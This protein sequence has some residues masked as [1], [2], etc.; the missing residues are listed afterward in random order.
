[1]N[2]GLFVAPSVSPCKTFQTETELARIL[3][4]LIHFLDGPRSR[5]IMFPVGKIS[6]GAADPT[7]TRI[8]PADHTI[9]RKCRRHDEQRPILDCAVTMSAHATAGRPHTGGNRL[10]TTELKKCPTTAS[11]GP[12]RIPDVRRVTDRIRRLRGLWRHVL[13]HP[14]DGGLGA[15]RNMKRPRILTPTRPLRTRGRR[16]ALSA[17]FR[18]AKG[19]HAYGTG[20]RVHP[21]RI[22]LARTL[23]PR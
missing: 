15:A 5:S 23:E 7:K 2:N 9:A 18:P 17:P 3:I 21:K 1:M 14:A 8:C 19:N 22:S 4:R 20:T 12:S 11:T 13:P 10:R 16:A 6:P